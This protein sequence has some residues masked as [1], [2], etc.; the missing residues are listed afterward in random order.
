[1]TYSVIAEQSSTASAKPL[2]PKKNVEPT[3]SPSAQESV[4]PNNRSPDCMAD[5]YGNPYE[6]PD[7]S[8]KD[9]YNA[10]PKHCFERSLVRSFS[11][12]LR[13]LLCVVITG[14]LAH[15]LIPLLPSSLI[16]RSMAWTT[17]GF[18]QSLFFTGLWVLSHECGHS[19]FS[20]YN[21][22]NDTVGWIVH[23]AL[24]VPYF[25][26]KFTHGTHHKKNAHMTEDTVFV[27]KTAEVKLNR[28]TGGT[29]CDKEGKKINLYSEAFYEAIN[30]SPLVTSL[31]VFLQQSLGWIVHLFT[32]ATGQYPP[33][34]AWYKMNHFHPGA[35]MFR[36]DQLRAVLLSDLGMLVAFGVLIYLI[37]KT[38]LS[39]VA[40]YYGIPYY[41]VNGWLVLITYLQHT[42]PL[43]ARYDNR[44]WN[45]TR[46]ALVSVDRDFGFIGK[47][48]FH[49]IIETHVLHHL[50][51]RIPF[52]NA[53]EATEAVRPLLGKFY[54]RDT[55]NMF[56]ALY[57]AFRQCQWVQ[58]CGN[59][60]YFF[61]N[62]NKGPG[63]R[64]LKV[65]AV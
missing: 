3:V 49:D 52:Y 62:A 16:V 32:N 5:S 13:D 65:K 19:A 20:P 47:H 42:D 55:T 51:S 29:G 11:Y 45:F 9:V 38:S 26:W 18:I 30:E 44:T 37:R 27:P 57:R 12:L 31:N 61:E 28:K 59:G 56:V 25:S 36:R 21:W 53:R 10:I 6:L 54:L 8:M 60:V 33:G 63:D 35:P 48:L 2:E 7:I 14:G 50:I 58:D 34:Y 64:R 17:Y 46:G 23:S 24:F 43:L 22:V 41:F 15:K 4:Y 39:T 1:M 40:L